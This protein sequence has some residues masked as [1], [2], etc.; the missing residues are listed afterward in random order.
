MCGCFYCEQVF[1][2]DEISTW[3]DSGETALCPFCGIDSVIGSDSGF[4][5]N[6]VFLEEMSREYF[7]STP[8]LKKIAIERGK[9]NRESQ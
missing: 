2:S 7:S 4:T 6:E 8:A 1:S 9:R 5:P 3:C